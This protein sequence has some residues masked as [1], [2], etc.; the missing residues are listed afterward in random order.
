[1]SRN[2]TEKLQRL[3][4]EQTHLVLL[5]DRSLAIKH[6][7]RSAFDYGDVKS[8]W[9]PTGGRQHPTEP[10]KDETLMVTNAMGDIKKFPYDDVPQCLGGA[11]VLPTVAAAKGQ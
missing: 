8:E 11:K 5:L 10:H 7:W 1:M 9:I 3:L 2:T 6:L 4:T